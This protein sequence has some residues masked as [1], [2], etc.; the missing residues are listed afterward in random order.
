MRPIANEEGRVMAEKTIY[1]YFKQNI[2]VTIS[3]HFSTATL[4]QLLV[5]LMP[6]AALVAKKLLKLG[7]FHDSD[8]PVI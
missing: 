3:G 5:A 1:D 7:S 8:A 4:K 2:K 6:S